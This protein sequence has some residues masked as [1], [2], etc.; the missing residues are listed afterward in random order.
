[1][2]YPA[3]NQEPRCDAGE[4]TFSAV[5][6]GDS[7]LVALLE[8]GNNA[9]LASISAPFHVAPH[10]TTELALAFVTTSNACDPRPCTLVLSGAVNQTLSCIPGNGNYDA[11]TNQ[12]TRFG[13]S[14]HTV[15][16][17]VAEVN[18][19]LPFLGMPQVGPATL[20]GAPPAPFPAYV[21]LR[22]TANVF[23]EATLGPPAVGSMAFNITAAAPRI[24]GTPGDWC[25]HGTL[26]TVLPGGPTSS[27]T[28]HADF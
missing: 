5:V 6:P 28:L 15:T 4:A 11:T 1:M 10:A 26:D 7:V 3:D 20:L 22:T 17:V 13:I 16:G 19:S 25:L 14:Q 2:S 8:N 9:A 18:S 21:Q 23:F 12:T 24:G 27:V